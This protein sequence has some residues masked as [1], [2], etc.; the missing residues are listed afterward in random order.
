MKAKWTLNLY[1][2]CLSFPSVRMTAMNYHHTQTHELKF[3][4]ICA[5]TYATV[6]VRRQLAGIG[7]L[8]LHVGPWNELRF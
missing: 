3:M 4:C 7:S 8:Q 1:L 2:S 5:C 6:D